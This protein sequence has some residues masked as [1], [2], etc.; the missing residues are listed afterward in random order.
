MAVHEQGFGLFELLEPRARGAF[1]ACCAG[2]S[3]MLIA[4]RL[5]V[6]GMGVG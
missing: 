1:S 6:D 4:E 2:G 5:Q 3:P